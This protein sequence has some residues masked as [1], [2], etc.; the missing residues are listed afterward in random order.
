MKAM[1]IRTCYEKVHWIGTLLQAENDDIICSLNHKVYQHLKLFRLI[2]NMENVDLYDCSWRLELESIDANVIQCGS[3]LE[4]CHDELQRLNHI[5][6]FLSSHQ[7]IGTFDS[8]MLVKNS[9]MN[10]LLSLQVDF[11]IKNYEAIRN[12]L[13]VN[14]EINEHQLE[15]SNKSSSKART[16]VKLLNEYMIVKL[17][18]NIIQSNDATQEMIDEHLQHIRILLKTINDGEI[19]FRLLQNVFT[20]VFLR[21]E[22]IRK[23]KRKRKNS[24][25]QSGS[26][27]NHINSHTT[28]V[29]DTTVETL[30]TGF[31]CLKMSLKA[32]MNSMR[33]FLMGLDQM[34]FYQTCDADLKLKFE[35]MLK[36]VD[37]CL[38]RMSIIE[39]ESQKKVKS[40]QSVTEWITMHA[41]DNITAPSLTPEI[42]S[43][44]EKKIPKKKVY[45]KKLKKRPKVAMKSD[46]NDEASDEPIDFQLFTETSLTEN[47]ENRVQSRSTESQRRVRS[48]ISSMLMDPE[49]LV[50]VCML[51]DDQKSVEKVIQVS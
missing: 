40:T 50:T 22:H 38:W 21:F 3:T 5:F 10:N 9:I 35:T 36:N 23:T 29:S 32:I 49:S 17:Y 37:N 15:I 51:K 4:L 41:G 6:K 30:Q 11:S 12:L 48:L 42:T 13:K 8:K 45:R 26:I 25:M 47:S 27:S 1:F 46:E 31:V 43:E 19:I 24:E 20:L 28:D 16:E 44:D 33:L 18:L 14:Q 2:L 7:H 34:K 39:S